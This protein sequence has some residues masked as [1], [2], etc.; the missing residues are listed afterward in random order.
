MSPTLRPHGAPE[1]SLEPN[2][3]P[4]QVSL[5]LRKPPRHRAKDDKT[6]SER[7]TAVSCPSRETWIRLAKQDKARWRDTKTHG[8]VGDHPSTWPLRSCLELLFDLY[9]DLSQHVHNCILT[10]KKQLLHLPVRTGQRFRR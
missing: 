8:R 2:V 10:A 7:L 6:G 3:P 1:P 9:N 5:M 4:G